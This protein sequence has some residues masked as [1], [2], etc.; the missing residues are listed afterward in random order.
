MLNRIFSIDNP[1]ASK[2]VEYG[3]LNAIHY[4]APSDLADVGNLCPHASVGCRAMC[5]GWTSGHAGILSAGETLNN[6]RRSRI[7]K[8]RRFMQDRNIYLR[9]MVQAVRSA[10]QK[11]AKESLRLCVRLNGSTDIAWEGIKFNNFNLFY[12][13]PD[14]QFVDYTKNPRRMMD[15]CAG[16]LPKN[17]HLTF[18]RSETNH[19]D[20]MRVLE[21]GGNVAVVFRDPLPTTW[22][23][24]DV[25]NG[26]LHD[27][28]HLD[29][30]G[31]VVGLSPKGRLA[32][33]D[34]TGFVLQGAF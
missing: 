31:V 2:A 3:W 13:F 22:H 17:Y 26:D 9:D 4:M 6:V 32:K 19:D 24:Y 16:E 20:C 30:K 11:A 25:I 29:R 5:L 15:H 18:S 23:G 10:K 1:K 34:R 28:R 27:L 14:I 8:A 7:E 21:A 33:N 12:M